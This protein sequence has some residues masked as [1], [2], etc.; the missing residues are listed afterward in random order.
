VI[1]RGHVLFQNQF[2]IDHN[3]V[4]LRKKRNAAHAACRAI[5]EIDQEESRRYSQR[6][7]GG[8]M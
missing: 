7:S 4:R 8:S 5:H 6:V 1:G 3:D 2:T